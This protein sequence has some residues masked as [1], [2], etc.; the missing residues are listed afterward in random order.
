VAVDDA[1]IHRPT[2]DD[3]FLVLTGQHPDAEIQAEADATARERE[4]VNA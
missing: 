4:A 1:G 3:V 2:L